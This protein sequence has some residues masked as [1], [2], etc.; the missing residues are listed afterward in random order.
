LWD[1]LN[2]FEFVAGLAELK[3]I[4]SEDLELLFEYPLRRIAKDEQIMAK[5]GEQSYEHLDSL[6][7]GAR[8]S[9]HESN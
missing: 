4:T 5:L 8:F 7:R 6:L 2:F 3:Q 9:S 1:Y